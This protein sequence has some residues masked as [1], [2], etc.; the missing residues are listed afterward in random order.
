MTTRVIRFAVTIALILSFAAAAQADFSGYWRAVHTTCDMSS[1]FA[2]AHVLAEAK[3][4]EENIYW[5]LLLLQPND[6]E[7]IGLWSLHDQD[8]SYNSFVGDEQVYM[9][10]YV[11]FGGDT[12]EWSWDYDLDSGYLEAQLLSPYHMEISLYAEY[13]YSGYFVAADCVRHYF[14]SSPPPPLPADEA[15]TTE[16]G[17]SD[18][19]TL[20]LEVALAEQE[21][22]TAACE[23]ELAA[24]R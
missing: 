22:R 11:P 18:L 6:Y 4:E 15:E 19:R 17:T 3:R 16:V 10:A 1:L 20:E 14:H 2:P 21:A 5:L 13:V 8:P 7:V 24:S 9:Q 23:A 12:F